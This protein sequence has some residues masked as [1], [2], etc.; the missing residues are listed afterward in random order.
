MLEPQM[1]NQEGDIMPYFSIETNQT[2]DQ[3]SNRGLI[4]KRLHSLPNCWAN[5]NRMS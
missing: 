5:P 3:A 4:K 1:G 2:I